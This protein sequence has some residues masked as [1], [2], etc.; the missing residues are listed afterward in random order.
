LHSDTRQTVTRWQ[1]AEEPT[2]QGLGVMSHFVIVMKI[3]PMPVVPLSPIVPSLA[4]FGK[5]KTR[6]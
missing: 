1:S 6:R 2:R 3:L 4:S 5:W